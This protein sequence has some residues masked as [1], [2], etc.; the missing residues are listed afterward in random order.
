M[1]FSK[2]RISKHERWCNKFAKT[3]TY[4][5]WLS[6]QKHVTL[7]SFTV[8]QAWETFRFG[9][10]YGG[11]ERKCHMVGRSVNVIL[12]PRSLV[13][14]GK[15][16]EKIARQTRR[17]G[18][19]NVINGGKVVRFITSSSAE[20]RQGYASTEDWTDDGVSVLW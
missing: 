20:G 10:N 4:L 6:G 2:C 18:S 7:E 8:S 5:S 19:C 14:I 17:A 3:A 15:N 16:A 1:T 9:E 11:I 12:H 13:M